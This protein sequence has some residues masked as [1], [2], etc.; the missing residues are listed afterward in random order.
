M[1]DLDK[2]EQVIQERQ[3]GGYVYSLDTFVGAAL[4]A[5]L[6]AAREALSGVQGL[7]RL[8]CEECL[9]F[10]GTRCIA[11]ARCSYAE[12]LALMAVKP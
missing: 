10:D 8:A 7:L 12:A 5:E 3:R 9:R 1:I 6:R 4:I 11:L 2:A